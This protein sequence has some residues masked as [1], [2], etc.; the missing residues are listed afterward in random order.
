M[1]PVLNR[2]TSNAYSPNFQAKNP[3]R[4][5]ALSEV[6]QQFK[7]IFFE[8]LPFATKRG[9]TPHCENP[10]INFVNSAIRELEAFLDNPRQNLPQVG[11]QHYPKMREIN[12][13]KHLAAQDVVSGVRR[14]GENADAHQ[15]E[16][17]Y[18]RALSVQHVYDKALAL[19]QEGNYEEADALIEQLNQFTLKLFDGASF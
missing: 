11:H 7:T 13:Q 1:Q 9:F 17:M 2:F 4:T 3:V 8:H 14:N 16:V 15:L 10:H 5:G 6:A 18:L 12:N 19:A